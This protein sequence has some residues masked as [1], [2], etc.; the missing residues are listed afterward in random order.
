LQLTSNH[1]PVSHLF[2]PAKGFEAPAL[3]GTARCATPCW[4]RWRANCRRCAAIAAGGWRLA[5]ACAKGHVATLDAGTDALAHSLGVT[6]I[7]P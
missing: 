7:C 3:N 6:L 5:V 2:S 4:S 1:G